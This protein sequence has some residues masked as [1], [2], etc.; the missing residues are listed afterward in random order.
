M[1]NDRTIYGYVYKEVAFVSILSGLI[2]V[3]IEVWFNLAY[4]ILDPCY[5]Q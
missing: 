5:V 4:W 1:N 3:V 2:A